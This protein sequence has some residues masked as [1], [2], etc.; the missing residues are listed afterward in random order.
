VWTDDRPDTPGIYLFNISNDTERLLISSYPHRVWKPSIYG[1]NLGY[2]SICENENKYCVKYYN[3]STNTT[4]E[5]GRGSDPVVWGD[6]ILYGHDGTYLYNISK[7]TSI[8]ITE[9]WG[10]YDIWEN[11]VVLS[12]DGDIYLYELDLANIT[13]PDIP[14]A[15]NNTNNTNTSSGID[16]FPIGVTVFI[17]STLSVA[18]ITIKCIKDKEKKNEN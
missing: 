13:F 12:S 3:I 18:A 1:D 16:Y 17:G 10:Q 4:T 2:T 11:R 9:K 14:I 15:N 6:Y 8:R 5:V 7:G